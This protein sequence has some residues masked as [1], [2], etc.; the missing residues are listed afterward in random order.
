MFWLRK[1][2]LLLSDQ[3]FSTFCEEFQC[4]FSLF[5]YHS[6]HTH[7]H[8]VHAIYMLLAIGQQ[9]VS[10]LNSTHNVVSSQSKYRD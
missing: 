6:N 9:F 5:D 4:C 7:T 3:C 2:Q 1:M 8:H 10:E